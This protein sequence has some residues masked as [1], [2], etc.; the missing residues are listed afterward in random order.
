MISATDYIVNNA[1]GADQQ[2]SA[3][4]E[5]VNRKFL[6]AII[7]GQDLVSLG[8]LEKL[9]AMIGDDLYAA[10]SEENRLFMLGTAGT[11]DFGHSIDLD[12]VAQNIKE[13]GDTE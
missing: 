3:Y 5:D 4:V 6:D 7:N 11:I 12:A 2:T 9:R 13:Y 8:K 1:Y 10:L